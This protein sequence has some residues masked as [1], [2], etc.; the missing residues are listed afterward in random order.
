M[1]NMIIVKTTSTTITVTDFIFTVS[2]T[3]LI[4][5]PLSI[6]NDPTVVNIRDQ[7][8]NLR[9]SNTNL[10]LTY[11]PAIINSLFIEN[12][13]KNPGE[14]SD[15]VY[16]FSPV[17]PVP[18]G[19][20]IKL[21]FPYFNDNSGAIGNQILSVLMSINGGTSVSEIKVRIKKYF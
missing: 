20:S 2:I 14:I 4:T 5:N 9:D 19:A 17:F 11:V 3:S 1:G 15:L 18:L 16:K 10:I 6:Y 13:N 8:G 12:I 21:D 7:N